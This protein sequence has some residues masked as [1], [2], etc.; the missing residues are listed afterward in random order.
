M[1]EIPEDLIYVS[2]E[3]AAIIG[4]TIKECKTLSLREFSDLA[5]S[6]GYDLVVSTKK[7]VPEGT[8]HLRMS[9][10]RFVSEHVEP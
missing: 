7:A 6:A 3:F 10:D 2:P 9:V 4:R 8:G 1:T 5:S